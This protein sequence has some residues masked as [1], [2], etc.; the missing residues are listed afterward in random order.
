MC[1]QS[2][3]PGVSDMMRRVIKLG[4]SLLTLPGLKETFGNWLSRQQPAQNL[5]IVG[6]GD[7]VEAVRTLDSIHHLPSH[8]THWVSIDLMHTTCQLAGAILGNSAQIDRPS[9]LEQWLLGS[10]PSPQPNPVALVS[11]LA[12]RSSIA[13][14][15]FPESWDATSDS[16][17]AWFASKIG[18]SELIVLKSGRGCDWTSKTGGG[19][20]DAEILGFAERGVVDRLFPQFASGVPCV[21]IEALA[22]QA[23]DERQSG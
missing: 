2:G 10:D 11:P 9:A 16:I 23:I 22:G 1:R 21:R 7:L 18:A 20:T 15:G 19:L 6:G 3:H 17:S 14:S 5:A 8:Q 12:Y 13:E 4:G